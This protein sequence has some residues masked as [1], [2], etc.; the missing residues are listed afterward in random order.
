[1]VSRNE[2]PTDPVGGTPVTGA[3]PSVPN[4]DYQVKCQR[5]FEA[6]L[7]SMPAIAVYA[8]HRAAAELGAGSNVILAWSKPAR[9]N[10]EAL[11]ANNQVPY[12]TSQTD[13]RPGPVVLEVPAASDKASLYGQIVDL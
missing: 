3:K 11:T 7:W 9:P 2:M 12:I 8:F 4:L 10:L 6:V 1:M 13:L 5:A